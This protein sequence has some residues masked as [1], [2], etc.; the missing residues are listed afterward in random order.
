MILSSKRLLFIVFIKTLEFCQT[1]LSKKNV[2][3]ISFF[4]LKYMNHSER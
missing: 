2:D 3:D 4:R 1:L